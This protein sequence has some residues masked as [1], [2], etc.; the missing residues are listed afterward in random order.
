VPAVTEWACWALESCGDTDTP[1]Q[2]RSYEGRIPALVGEDRGAGQNAPAD[3]LLA[4][5]ARTR[6][7]LGDLRARDQLVGLLLSPN[8]MAREI[9]IG[10]LR[11]RYGEDR[12]Y[13]AAAEPNER[14]AAVERWLA[15]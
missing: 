8:A 13:D 3:R 4:R 12:G 15:R 5:S 11:D 6:L 1:A 9:A 10:A 2:L 14:N 7:L